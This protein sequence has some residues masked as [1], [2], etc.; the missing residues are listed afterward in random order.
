VSSRAFPIGLFAAGAGNAV[1]DAVATARVAADAGLDAV[2]F[3]Q[4]AGLDALTLLAVVA[5]EVPDIRLGS[6]VVPIQGR[7]PFALAMQ[8]LAVADAAGPGRFTLGVGVTHASM[9]EAWY[10]VPFRGIVDVCTEVVTALGGLLGPERSTGIDGAHVS[11][12]A[13][14]SAAGAPVPGLVLAALAPRMVEL[15]GRSTDGTI[16]WMTGPTALGRDIVPRLRAAAEG[17]GRPAPRVVV[18]IQVCVTDDVP[19]ARERIAPMMGLSAALPV[20]GRQLAAEGVDDFT[21]LALVGSEDAVTERLQRYR[22]AG[23]TEL[24]AHVLGTD[25]ERARTLAFLR[26]AA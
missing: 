6:G 14:I 25:E 9:S 2:W 26:G 1:A 15:A 20:Y 17:A 8:A 23:M 3:P 4:T 11:S 21:E 18:G 7:H 10:G 19:G 24:C 5:R 12:H 13:T 16:T 22:E